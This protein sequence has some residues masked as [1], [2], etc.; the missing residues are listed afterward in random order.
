[1]VLK[2]SQS[3]TSEGDRAFLSYTR[4]ELQ[5]VIGTEHYGSKLS[6]A[7][8]HQRLKAA[9]QIGEVCFLFIWRYLFTNISTY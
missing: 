2:I 3:L 8:D 1:M 6:N 5:Y 4:G 7:R 9:T